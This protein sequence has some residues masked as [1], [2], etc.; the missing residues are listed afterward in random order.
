MDQITI[1]MKQDRETPNTFRFAAVEDDVSPETIYVRKSV[2]RKM[3]NPENHHGH[4]HA[5]GLSTHG[6]ARPP[7]TAPGPRAFSPTGQ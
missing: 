7:R 4:H 2:L 3:G 1:Q 6:Q 5:R